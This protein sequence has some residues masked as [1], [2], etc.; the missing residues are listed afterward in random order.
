ML[1]ND[2]IPSMFNGGTQNI[3]ANFVDLECD[4]S[5]ILKKTVFPQLS[6]IF[7]QPRFR[8]NEGIFLT[9]PAF[10]VRSCEVAIIWPDRYPEN[11]AID[12]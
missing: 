5:M 3:F 8:W 12:I 7:H 6:I 10:G 1:S 9:K 11:E 2:P 4:F